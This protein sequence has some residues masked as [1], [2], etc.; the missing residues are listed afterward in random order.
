M[1]W[2]SRAACLYGFH[3][4]R[5]RTEQHNTAYGHILE[6]RTPL[7]SAYKHTPERVCRV[8]SIIEDVQGTPRVAAFHNE[9]ELAKISVV[10]LLCYQ[11]PFLHG[12]S[13]TNLSHKR[14]CCLVTSHGTGGMPSSR[15]AGHLPSTHLAY[16]GKAVRLSGIPR[17]SANFFPHILLGHL[18]HGSACLHSSAAPFL[19]T[20]VFP[21][22]F[23]FSNNLSTP[24]REYQPYFQDLAYIKV[25]FFVSTLESQRGMTTRSGETV[26]Y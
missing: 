6:R 23:N 14:W 18:V 24:S 13:S 15:E 7:Y 11:R 5:R 25:F 1:W 19:L 17:G 4:E 9:S 8:Q 22:L 21:R 3:R 12:N 2:Q 26:I 10:V 16:L 20:G